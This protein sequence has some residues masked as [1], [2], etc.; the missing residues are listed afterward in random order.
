MSSCAICNTAGARACTRCRSISYCCR[1]C[2]QKDWPSHRLL[3][4]QFLT[5]PP[6]PSPSHRR[7]ILLRPEAKTPR[8]EWVRCIK[9]ENHPDF[10]TYEL[11]EGVD[12]LLLS[13]DSGPATTYS[14]ITRVPF[15]RNIPRKRDLDHTIELSFRDDI[16]NDSSLKNL[17]V[18]EVTK[19]R[20]VHDWRGPL[21]F[22]RKKE[23]GFDPMSY[24]DITLQDFRDIVDYL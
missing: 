12:T 11:N 10:G 22:M 15:Q 23:V 17:A 21:V 19:G 18:V 24:E 3:C 4:A 5:Q 8:L 16:L 9:V 1:E 6:R 20:A 13:L 14:G 2:Q 7:A